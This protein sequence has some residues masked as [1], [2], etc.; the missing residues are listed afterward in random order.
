[1]S[2]ENRPE[3]VTDSGCLIRREPGHIEDFQFTVAPLDVNFVDE[4]GNIQSFEDTSLSPVE[5][6][7]KMRQ[8]KELPKTSGGIF[9]KLVNIYDAN[10]NMGKS[11]LS[12]H[13]T[14]KHS[15]VFKN[16][17]KAKEEVESRYSQIFNKK[18]PHL[19]IG[20]ID[21]KLFS[22]PAGF[23]VE[24]AAT[25][26]NEGYPLEEINRIIVETIPKTEV[27]VAPKQ[28]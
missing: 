7:N 15:A 24:Q 9:N 27:Y 6:Y 17:I 3:I 25:L 11:I 13:V 22:V 16:A 14:D 28:L 4:N 19:F 18:K 8:S 26:A 20:L 10:I 5:F 12:I 1:M 2:I 21:S 23:L